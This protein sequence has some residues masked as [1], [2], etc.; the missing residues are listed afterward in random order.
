MIKVGKAEENKR[1][2]REILLNTAF[3]LFSTQGINHTAVGDIVKKAGIAKG[4]FYLYFKDKYDIRDKLI[5]NKT[6][7]LFMNAIRSLRKT[8]IIDFEEQVIFIID[9][10]IEELKSDKVLLKTI[11]KDLSWGAYRKVFEKPWTDEADEEV[12]YY[13]LFIEGENNAHIG[14]KNPEITLFLIIEMIGGV[15]YSSILFEQPT[16]ID[17]LKPY[18]YDSIHQ[19]IQAGIKKE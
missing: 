3:E 18:I 7:D 1:I 2:K 4:T 16:N 6:S 17:E 8:S 5:V 13:S 19:I 15:A 9:H 12:S 14:L 11:A 10:V